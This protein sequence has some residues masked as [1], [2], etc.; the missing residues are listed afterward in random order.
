M[1]PAIVVEHV[2]RVFSTGGTRV[3]ALEDISFSVGEG[4]IVGLL[5]ENGAGKTTLTKILSTLLL[6][7]AGRARIRGLDVVREATRVRAMQSVILG[8]DRGLYD[9][10]SARENLRFFGMLDGIP[11]RRLMARL[12]AA[13]DEVGLADAA[14]RT[15]GSYSKGMRQ[16]LHIAVGMISQPAV[17]LLDEPTVGLDPVEAARLRQVIGKLRAQGVTVLLTS[18]Y[19]LDVEELADRVVI[20]EGGRITHD[21]P[22][23]RFSASLGYTATIVVKGQGPVPGPQAGPADGIVGVRVESDADGWTMSLQ[24]ERW[25]P[26]LFSGL[27]KMFGE[28]SILGMDVQPTRLEDAFIRLHSAGRPEK[29]TS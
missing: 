5:G 16:R 12:D 6:P 9:Q 26:V 29:K 19:L 1:E 27:A 25:S 24:L 4:E 3:A 7:T 17:L 22:L 23:A 28:A 18:H 21:M 14:R 13:L 2:S 15:V 20:L 11:H 8:G 10:L